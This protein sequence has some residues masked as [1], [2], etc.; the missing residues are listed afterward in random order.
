MGI[1]TKNGVSI[2][3]DSPGFKGAFKFN[4]T[5]SIHSEWYSQS[6]FSPLTVKSKL[7]INPLL[8]E[9]DLANLDS[10]PAC[11]ANAVESFLYAFGQ[12]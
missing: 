1:F 4:F 2:L 12:I 10:G 11:F 7:S 5:T 3:I 8:S 9:S 6:I